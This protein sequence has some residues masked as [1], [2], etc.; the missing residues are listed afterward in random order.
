MIKTTGTATTE[1]DA[2]SEE[3]HL[4]TY[5]E[6]ERQDNEVNKANASLIFTPE[7]IP[8]R[9]NIK[10]RFGLTHIETLLY[11]FIR[12]YKTDNSIRFY[13]TSEQLG[14]VLDCAEK[15]IDNAI[16]ALKKKGLIQTSQKRKADGGTMRFIN[17]VLLE[18][19]KSKFPNSGSLSSPKLQANKNKIKENKINT[20]NVVQKAEFGNSDINRLVETFKGEFNLPVLDGT[21]QENRNYAHLCIKKFGGA[22]KVE[23]LIKAA[24]QNRYWGN[25]VASFKKLYYNGISIIAETRKGGTGNGV[26]V[27]TED[28]QV[29]HSS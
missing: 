28:G 14:E 12:F 9:V 25:K 29:Y 1:H 17:S 10:K 19:G 6:Q 7:F 26:A 27:I 4:F 16:S 20:T 18:S 15:T 21:Q 2:F 24:R 8:Y 11:G 13:F 3:E 22:D 5:S 23:L